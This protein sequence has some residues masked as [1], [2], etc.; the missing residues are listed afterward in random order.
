MIDEVRRGVYKL[1]GYDVFFV[2]TS[3]RQGRPAASIEVTDDT[4]WLK[5]GTRWEPG[6]AERLLTKIDQQHYK[7][8]FDKIFTLLQ[9]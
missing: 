9:L 8:F 1:E 2:V 6:Q 4:I 7:T 5:S 3:V